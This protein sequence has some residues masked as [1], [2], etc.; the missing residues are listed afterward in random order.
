MKKLILS[1]DD[2]KRALKKLSLAVN[3]KS[4]LP[5]LTNIYCRITNGQLEM[6][7]SDVELT[8]SA[9]LKA[10]TK[11][12]FEMLIPFDFFNKL[13]GQLKSVPVEIE[14]VS[15]KKVVL[16]ES[17]NDF[18]LNAIEKT[19]TFPK[20]PAETKKNLIE[21]NDQFIKLLTTGLD[22]AG[23]DENRPAMTA[24]CLDMKKT[25][26]ASE[27]TMA[28]TDAH[29]MFT[30]KLHMEIK[31]PEQLLF[32]QKLVSAADGLK[33]IQLAWNKERISIKGAE[34]TIWAK[35][36]D[37]AYPNYKAV[38]PNTEANLKIKKA[39]LADALNKACL[40]SDTTKHTDIFL[41]RESGKIHLEF[42][43]KDNSRNGHLI[44]DGEYTGTTEMIGVN[45][46]KMLTVLGQVEAEN[47]SLHISSASK[48]ILVSSEENKDYLGLVMP[49]MPQTNA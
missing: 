46:K 37:A 12:E 35:R 48:A 14:L 2:L 23:K 30:H 41:K 8:I 19:D 6:I 26:T 47:I 20:I 7:T 38:I 10:D 15:S 13:I 31:E 4:I 21:L 49:L 16:R 5:V 11:G 33:E 40:S 32:S 39:D 24:V 22:S 9:Q 34:F 1:S 17:G 36:I 42:I 44:V 28:S 29:I 27:V 18:E 45:A 3:P 43:D 25:E